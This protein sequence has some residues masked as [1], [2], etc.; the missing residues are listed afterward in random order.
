MTAF[1]V[2]A[3]AAAFVCALE[4]GAGARDLFILVGCCNGLNTGGELTIIRDSGSD[5]ERILKNTAAIRTGEFSRPGTATL[6]Y[7]GIPN[8]MHFLIIPQV[9]VVGIQIPSVGSSRIFAAGTRTD[10]SPVDQ[11]FKG[12]GSDVL[13]KFYQKTSSLTPLALL[14]GNPRATTALLARGA[15]DRF[16]LGALRTRGGDDRGADYND[17]LGDFDLYVRAGGG[18]IDANRFDHLWVADAS[19]TLGGDFEPGIG[20]YASLL[21]QY[22]DPTLNFSTGHG[23]ITRTGNAGSYSYSAIAG[24]ENMPVNYVSFYNSLRFANW[25][26]NGQGANDTETGAYTLEGGTA[27]PSNGETVTRNAGATIVLTSEDEWY[28]AAYHNAIGLSATDY[29]DYPA[30]LNAQT[31]CAA[32]TAAAN[33]ANCDAPGGNGTDAD[34]DDLTIRGSFAG[35]AS[36][37]GTFDQGGNVWEWNEKIWPGL[38]QIR[39]VRGGTFVG[40]AELLRASGVFGGGATSESLDTGFRLAMIPGGYVPEP[41]TGLLVFAGLFGLAGW[42]GATS[43][44]PA[45]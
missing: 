25:M 28:K 31:T 39:G 3:V 40:G 17:V 27:T 35:S 19:V 9:G 32:P 23:G 7:L 33:S 6:D 43:A 41:G 22:R 4:T 13:A 30:G 36:P 1:R 12:E 8:A 38:P 21:G 2:A 11:F 24:R 10:I 45:G 5:L 26:N 42:V 18:G 20:L 15:F 14:D 34:V 29:F 37:Y 44:E 16:G